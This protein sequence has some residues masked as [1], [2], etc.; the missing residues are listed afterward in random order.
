MSTCIEKLPHSCGSSDGLQVFEDNQGKVDGYCFACNTYVENPYDGLDKTPTK[1][2]RKKKSQE[3]IQQELDEISELLSLE[4]PDRKL[5]KQALAHFGIKIGLSEYDG[6]TPFFHFYPYTTTN[7]RIVAYKTRVI[8]N[9]AMWSVGS[10]KGA[11]LFGWQQ[12][13]KTGSNKL[14]ITEGELDAVALY[15]ALKQY[16]AGGKWEHLDPAVVSLKSG[17]SGAV[18]DIQAQYQ[19]IK[20]YFNEVVLVFDQDDAGKKAAAE[21]IKVFP[22]F[23]V[24]TIPAKDANEAVKNGRSRGLATAVLFNAQSPKN[25]RIVPAA[26]IIEDASKAPEPGVSYPWKKLTELT[27]GLRTKETSYWGAGV[28]MG[29][30]ELVNALGSHLMISHKWPIFM[31]KP[32][33]ANVK[34]MKL[35]AGKVA[36]KFFH[37][38][39][40]P[41]DVEAYR[42]AANKISD[43]LFLL[44]LYQHIGW[45]NLKED[46]RYAVN[47]YGVKG[48]FI[49]PVT[50]L[51]NG[52]SAADQ[53]T[54]LQEFAQELAVMSKDLDF[55]AFIFC[56]LKAPD[57]G[58]PHERGGSVLSTQFAGSRAMMRSCNLMMGLEGNKDPE[59][60]SEQRNIRKLIILED[61]EFGV[62]GTVPLYWDEQTGLFNEIPS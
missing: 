9:K 1:N 28:K 50:N 44:D 10:I 21:V 41:F 42:E 7:D 51:I 14:F 27:R 29:K 35:M 15:Q 31:A 2:T 62:S 32:E 22:T 30:S 3:E 57:S 18:S 58:P 52:K 59:M 40:I 26:S 34:T 45:E 5:T 19:E 25:T 54:I 6:Q 13:I 11:E 60:P 47:E 12:A 38:P 61:R 8:H 46:I 24:A 17:A 4:L 20:Q 33:E 49:D 43:K 53:N 39:N 36:G 56:H 48:V 23:K 55:H 16:A 37:D